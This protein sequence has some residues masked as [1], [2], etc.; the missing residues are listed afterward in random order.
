M[1]THAE[2]AVL[3]LL[4]L[5]EEVARPVVDQMNEEDIRRIRAIASAMKEV[6]KDAAKKTFTEFLERSDKAVAVP[7]GGLRYLRRLSAGAIGE[8]RARIVFD[9]QIVES[10]L[11]KL[12]KAAPEDVAGLLANEPP[13]LAAAILSML[14]PISAAAILAALGEERQAA[15]VKHVSKMT[16]LPASVLEDVASALAAALPS[17]DATQVVNVDGVAKAAELLNASGKGASSTILANL[18]A[19]DPELANTVRMAMFT[20]DDLARLDSKA[21]R[22]LLREAATDRLTI[23]LKGANPA[24]TEAVFRGLSARAA[25]L[26]RDDLEN[27]GQIRK[28]DVDA[29]R[30][31][32]VEVALR[33]E[34]AGTISL[35]REEE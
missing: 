17:A 20:F 8:E 5:D 31:E 25:D 28:S 2:K 23:A 11:G 15:I 16:Q 4:S 9:D 19:E 30:K 24:V 7:R 10:P 22:G 35:G 6:P 32:I 27:M 18:E 14:S 34:A 12:E 33:L 29:A 21:M 1:L 3:F 13:Q 26:I